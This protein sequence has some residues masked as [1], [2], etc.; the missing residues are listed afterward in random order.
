MI[1]NIC[2]NNSTCINL[3][4]SYQCNCQPGY[5]GSNCQNKIDFCL[6]NPCIAS[7]TL[8]CQN[9]YD[10]NCFICVC[11]PGKSIEYDTH[12]LKFY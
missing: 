3:P 5:A 8:Y 9:N 10:L 1:P 6:N 12:C 4:G 2:L 7:N 11:R